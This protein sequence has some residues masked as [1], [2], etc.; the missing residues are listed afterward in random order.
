MSVDTLTDRQVKHSSSTHDPEIFRNL[1]KSPKMKEIS[2]I[3][4]NSNCDIDCIWNR[5]FAGSYW[6]EFF[7]N[8][9][10]STIGIAWDCFSNSY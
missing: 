6:L 3:Q 1:I 4:K 10:W 5:W 9:N 7:G 8:F 2:K